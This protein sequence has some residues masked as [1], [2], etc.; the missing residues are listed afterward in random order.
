MNIAII[1]TGIA[2]MTAAYLLQRDGHS[3]T[4]FEAEDYIGGHTHTIDVDYRGQNY[5]VDTGFIVFNRRTYPQFNALLDRLAVASKPTTMSFAVRCEKSGLEYCGNTLNTL[6]AQRRNLWRPDFYAMLGE[7]LRFNREAPKLLEAKETS[8]TLGEYLQRRRFKPSFVQHYLLPMAAA[9][10]SAPIGRMV[11]MPAHTFVRFCHNH[12]LLNIIDRPRWRVIE[13]GSRRYA[14]ALTY[15]YR[16]RIRTRCPVFALKRARGGV[17]IES[18]LG[19]EAFDAAVVATHSDQALALLAAPTPMERQVLGAI[20][21]QENAVVLHTDTR[22]LP[23]CRR[24]WGAWNYH[25][26]STEQTPVAVTYNMNILQG[27]DAP[28]T[29]CVTLNRLDAIDPSQILAQMTYHH[30]LLDNRAIGAQGR[31]DE[32]N[33]QGPVVYCGAYG[34]YGFHED[35]LVS[36]RAAVEHLK[37]HTRARAA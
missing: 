33:R 26:P 6:F 2:G 7:I 13:G 17:E 4:V 8:L 36:A 37:R 21:Y 3:L 28:V 32:L 5:A 20:A 15:H 22:L 31:L 30:P 1:G 14:E 9:I 35:G 11:D 18:P 10:W 16:S 12:G 24:A 29:F 25:I 19:R 23:H 34:G 27:I